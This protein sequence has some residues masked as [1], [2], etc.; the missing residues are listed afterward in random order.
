MKHSAMKRR[1]RDGR[2]HTVSTS[3]LGDPHKSKLRERFQ[4]IP[5]RDSRNRRIPGLY[6]RNG[7]YYAQLWTDAGNGK[8]TARRFALKNGDNEPVRTLQEA[9]EAVDIKR[10]ER[11]ERRLPTP[12]HKPRLVD[13]CATYFDKAKVQRKRLGTLEGERQALGRWCDHIG[14]VRIDR[15][16]TP[17][18]AAFIDR[19][20]KG[21][22]F[23]GRKL[24][25]ASERTANLDLMR[26]RNILKT[27]IDDGYLRE[28]PRMKMLDEPPPP[29]RKLVTPAQFGRLIEAART[30]CE[31]NG[32]QLADYLRFLAFS[33]AREQEA[34]RIKWADVDL[35]HERVTIGADGF[36]KNR[37]VRTVE[38]NSQLE[39]LLHEMRAR[40]APDCSW[41][42]PSP[43]RG[44]RD[45]HAKSF[46][47]SL[48]IARESAR[49]DWIGFH[50]LRHYF[51]S[52]CVMAGVDFMT[53][54]AWL[55]HKDGGILVG[56]VYGHL[57]DEHRSKAAKLVN[58]GLSIVRPFSDAKAQVPQRP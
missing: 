39:A 13:Y 24:G 35:E 37:E 8:K 11:R 55:G 12:G 38:F 7:R 42:F 47:E 19:R 48:K 25:P 18:I 20:L 33:G 3:N 43:Q 45:E 52:V 17:A 10:H 30:A 44:P 46:R 26:L 56:K 32:E 50:D 58:F 27:A 23:C 29:K 34:L 22:I 36:S 49:L 41:L 40:R 6:L 2:T 21:G 31:K 1:V 54:A 51:C 16:A 9:R 15:I 14:H 4:F 5:A 28:L 53:I 57:L